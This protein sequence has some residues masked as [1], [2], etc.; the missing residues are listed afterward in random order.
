M[1]RSAATFARLVLMLLLGVFVVGSAA[2]SPGLPKANSIGSPSFAQPRSLESLP[3]FRAAVD[4]VAVDVCVKGRNGQFLPGL[5]ADDFLILD[6]NTPQSV[7]FFS[8]EER[9]PLAVVLLIDRSASMSGPKLK[10]AKEAA[11]AFLRTLRPDDLVEVIA[12]NDHTSRLF[13]LWPLWKVEG[14][15]MSQAISDLS[16][17]GR[18]AL[19]EAVTVGLRDLA[20]AQRDATEDSRAAIVVLSDGEDTSSIIGFDDVLE[21]VRRSGVLVYAISVRTGKNSRWLAPLRELAQFA[22]DSGGQAVAVR[23]LA[24]LVPVYEEIGTELRH[25]YRLGY[26]PAPMSQ[27]GRWH[28]ISVRVP[29]KDVRVRARSGYYA[30]RPPHYSGDG[31]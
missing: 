13:S 10:R 27:D 28:S 29:G 3:R 12:F 9:V 26:V 2:Q 14:D 11:A 30:P 23:S 17:S 16:A 19:Y 6:G 31:S 1:T 8:A 22:Y 15:L 4:V 20:R 24:S 7:A 25:L 5:S 18:T 21:D